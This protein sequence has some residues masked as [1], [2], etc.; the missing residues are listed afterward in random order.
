MTDC[1]KSKI[2]GGGFFT[3][4]DTRLV[5]GIDVHQGGIQAYGSLIKGNQSPHGVGID[6]GNRQRDGV[7]GVI[8]EGLPGAIQKPEQVVAGGRAGF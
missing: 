8:V 2:A 6:F 4:F 7:S 3:G 5:V 1:C